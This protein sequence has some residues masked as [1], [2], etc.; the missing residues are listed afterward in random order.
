MAMAPNSTVPCAKCKNPA[1]KF[2]CDTCAKALCSQCKANHLKGKSTR[3]HEIVQYAKK[4][5]PKYLAGLMCHIH[6]ST[7]PEFW[8]DT[9]GVP[10]CISCITGKHQGHH[11]SK[12]TTVLSQKRDSMLEEMKMLR[13]TTISEWEAL[14]KEAQAF[15]AEYVQDIEKINEDLVTRSNEM[16]KQVKAIL[17]QSQTTLREMQ[18]SG[19]DHLD[20]QEKNLTDKLQQ[21]RADVQKFEDYLQDGDPNALLQFKPGT[22]LPKE[23][24]PSLTT[25]SVPVFTKGQNDKESMKKIFGQLSTEDISASKKP[26]T[27][28]SNTGHTDA[29][30]SEK[31]STP[32]GSLVPDP[33]VLTE[34]A[35]AYHYP[36]IACMEGGL[37]WV[38]TKM[39]NLQLMD[40][41][42]FVNEAF[43]MDFD[44][45]DMTVTSDCDLLLPD[46]G[47]SCIKSTSGKKTITTMFSTS[48]EPFGICCFH[49]NAILV[50]FPTDSKVVVYS[51]N[52]QIRRT[53]DQ[54]TFRYPRR[55]AVSKVNQDIYICDHETMSC[56][57]P[58]R[59][60][61]VGADGR[62]QYEYN[63]QDCSVFTPADVCTDQI[64]H[65]L[66]TDFDN[67]R[68]HILD[69]KGRFMQYILTSQQG[70]RWPVTIDVD[71]VGYLWV[72]GENTEDYYD[73]PFWVKVFRYMS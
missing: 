63:G 73:Y 34:F 67:H 21:L 39:N 15:K 7:D 49:N 58:G 53:L 46:F 10:I 1:A 42:G 45:H 64:G 25:V 27:I 37:A 29:K 30:D 19:L 11:V 28:R 2:H 20:A 60:L 31:T 23:I 71:G 38:E 40:R 52:G 8:C 56:N 18:K 22:I 3:H 51:R 26:S 13:G 43:E 65:V 48:G 4:L 72:G 69:Q 57:S 33:S 62:L 50:T 5:N 16:I 12:I 70:L 9:C 6:N 41:E 32:I 68:V 66:I 61:A 55:V 47:N 59:L 54:I 35:V 17:S 36:H 44:F 24:P 14:L